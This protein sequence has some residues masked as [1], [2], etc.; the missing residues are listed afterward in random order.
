MPRIFNFGLYP[1]SNYRI[2]Y[3]SDSRHQLSD[4]KQILFRENIKPALSKLNLVKM[5][6][7]QEFL[8]KVFHIEISHANKLQNRRKSF[9]RWS[10][11]VYNYL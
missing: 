8:L 1:S 5:F 11:D 2:N 6:T 3:P 10:N 7:E 9:D 4:P